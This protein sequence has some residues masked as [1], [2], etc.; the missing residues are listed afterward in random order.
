MRSSKDARCCSA[1]AS[2]AIAAS[3]SCTALTAS[4]VRDLPSQQPAQAA[5]PGC[6][7]GFVPLRRRLEPAVARLHLAAAILHGITQRL[8]RCFPIQHRLCNGTRRIERRQWIMRDA[9]SCQRG[10]QLLPQFR[11][12]VVRLAQITAGLPQSRPRFQCLVAPA[13]PRFQHIQRRVRQARR[14]RDPRFDPLQAQRGL[15]ELLL[16]VA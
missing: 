6:T 5:L 7:P 4:F 9:G 1:G 11:A 15:V 8:H 10:E 14:G 3:I 13:E 2:S 16:R 12:I